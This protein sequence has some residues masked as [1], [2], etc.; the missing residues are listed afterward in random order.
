MKVI[1]FIKNKFFI[2]KGLGEIGSNSK[3]YGPAQFSFKKNIFIGDNTTILGGARIQSYQDKVGVENPYIHIGDNCYIGYNNSILAGGQI[4][5]GNDVLI[6]SNTLI[7]SENHSIDP[8]N[9]TPYMN[10]KLICLDVEIRDGCWIGEKA[11]ILPGVTIGK[12]SII[13]AGSVVTRSVPDYCIAVGNPAKVIK[14][15]N[16]NNHKWEKVNQ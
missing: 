16:F 10:Q 8:E 5:I 2:N 12:K 14:K 4:V 9:D 7:T 11:I 6:A 3:I 1:N 15:Y 13:G